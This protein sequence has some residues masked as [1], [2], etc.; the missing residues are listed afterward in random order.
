VEAPR[1]D[2]PVVPGIDDLVEIGSGGAGVVY[3]GVQVALDRVVAVKVV[4]AAGTAEEALRRWRRE[5]TAMAR[6][7]SQPNIVAVYDGGVTDGGLPY[8]VMP[9]VTGGSLDERLHAT[10]RM[11]AAE[12]V[13]MG[14][15]LAGA[16]A[17]AHAAGVL[18]RD[19]KPANVLLGDDGEPQL[20]D[21]GI[22]Q[23]ADA[24]A[25]MT[26][27]VRATVSY[28]APEVLSGRPASP[29]SDVYGLAATLHACLTGAPPHPAREGEPLVAHALR[30]VAEPPADLRS[31]GVEPALAEVL[32]RAM[33]KDPADRTPSAAALAADLE[34]LAG[35]PPPAPPVAAPTTVLS[36]VATT[37]ATVGAAP[38]RAAPA[39]PSSRP[40]LIG[41]LVVLLVGL[42]AG[43]VLALGGDDDEPP[44]VAA[45]DPSVA[46]TA[47]PEGSTATEAPATTAV[48]VARTSDDLQ[49]AATGYLEA[50][51]RGD[52]EGAYA[53]TTAGFQAAQP[54]DGYVEFWSGFG[55][56]AVEGEPAVDEATG[57]VV[58]R[59]RLD[60]STESYAL[61]LVAGDGGGLLV[62][63]PRP[64]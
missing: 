27:G 40:W 33:A 54:F 47:T 17:A 7:S 1:T 46:T 25:T 39:P 34:R 49:V 44:P 53:M 19:V 38:Q 20:A 23:L 14:R 13:A 51:Q 60:G 61:E 55:E 12:V 37:T 41:A 3:R 50:L 56:I 4:R 21:F 42:V 18:H 6:L 26:V 32:E 22:A 2:L 24:T 62:D 43:L 59:L 11:A 36:P 16:L 30:V 63:G 58:V 48:A 64:R 9:Y 15:K 45:G 35:E 52:L 5:V 10:G 29:A 57:T 8:L 31:S 28:A